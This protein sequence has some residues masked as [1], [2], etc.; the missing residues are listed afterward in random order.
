MKLDLFFAFLLLAILGGSCHSEKSSIDYF[1]QIPPDKTPKIFAPQIIC[2]DNRFESKG[3]FSP[4]GKAFYFTITNSNFTSQKI[5]FTE[6][7]NGLWS[8]PD[9]AVF[10]KRFNNHEPFI[11]NDGLR[12]Y[13]TSDREKDTLENRRDLFVMEKHKV[14]WSEPIK[15]KSPVNSDY[16]ELLFNQSKNGTI[17]FT[18]NRPG[19]IGKWDIY[20]VKSSSGVYNT[21]ENI[22]SPINKIYAWDPCIAPDESYLVFSAGREDGYGQS[23]L[24]VSFKNNGAWTEPKNLG[25]QINTNGNDFG[26]FLSPD[27]KYLF[28]CRHDGIKGDIYWVD[29]NIINDYRIDL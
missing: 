3:T 17:Y 9:T 5:F 7:T 1:G 11:S 29:I 10:S 28:F 8:K 13:F 12:L 27:N 24:Y 19:G 16:A 18:S 15:L 21:L 20:L 2:L 22:G 6:F 4:D 26:P 14:L 23:D 25:N